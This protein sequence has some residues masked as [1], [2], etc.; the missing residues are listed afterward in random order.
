MGSFIDGFTLPLKNGQITMHLVKKD[1]LKSFRDKGTAEEW[2][3]EY[4]SMDTV[5]P[6]IVTL[7]SDAKFK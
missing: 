2:E 6:V 3:E 5:F 4:Y 7:T 1:I